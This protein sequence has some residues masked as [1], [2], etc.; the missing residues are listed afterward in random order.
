MIE[1]MSG[2]IMVAPDGAF[3]VCIL[4][5]GC[6][7]NPPCLARCAAQRAGGIAL[8]AAVEVITPDSLLIESQGSAADEAAAFEQFLDIGSNN[9]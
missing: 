4:A 1:H 9:L 7:Y 2:T 8:P 5:N 3:A 6:A